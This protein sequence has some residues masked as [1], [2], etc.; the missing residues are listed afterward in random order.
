MKYVPQRKAVEAR[1]AQLAIGN[2]NGAVACNEKLCQNEN[3]QGVVRNSHADPLS[4]VDVVV[5]SYG[6]RRTVLNIEGF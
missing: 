2:L 4:V 6:S 3:T 1:H 5:S